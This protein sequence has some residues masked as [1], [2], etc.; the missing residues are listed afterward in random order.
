[1]ASRENAFLTDLAAEQAGRDAAAAR[2]AAMT[3]PADSGDLRRTHQAVR[4]LA[5]QLGADPD[6]LLRCATLCHRRSDAPHGPDP[7]WRRAE[8]LAWNALT[9]VEARA[10]GS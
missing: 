3:I 6:R 7:L 9:L 2:A 10:I 8:R 1:M 4:A 5:R